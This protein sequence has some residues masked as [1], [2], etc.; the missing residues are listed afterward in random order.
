MR[1]LFSPGEA[2]G[3]LSPPSVSSVRPSISTPSLSVTLEKV[4]PP[5]ERARKLPPFPFSGRGLSR[6]PLI[7][8]HLHPK[9]AR[10]GGSFSLRNMLSPRYRVPSSSAGSGG[11]SGSRAGSAMSTRISPRS[12]AG[13]G[14]SGVER[15]GSRSIQTKS[16]WAFVFIS[17]SFYTSGSEKAGRGSG[18]MRPTTPMGDT[19]QKHPAKLHRWFLGFTSIGGI[20]QVKPEC[21]DHAKFCKK[22]ELFL[23]GAD[24]LDRPR[25]F[26]AAVARPLH[27]WRSAHHTERAPGGNLFDSPLSILLGKNALTRRKV[28]HVFLMF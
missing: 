10:F 13:G 3:G 15:I 14:P 18:M 8:F 23:L 19:D 12:V 22:T 9:N 25:R 5:H 27:R 16:S 24:G 26:E 4:Y 6:P 11:G 21:L 17:F 1:G 7:Q 20:S 28:S 2:V